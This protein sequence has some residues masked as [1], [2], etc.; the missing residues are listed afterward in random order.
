MCRPSLSQL[1]DSSMIYP[2]YVRGP[3][4]LLGGLNLKNGS[5]LS[6][7]DCVAFFYKTLFIS[8]TF[9]WF[10]IHLW[11]KIDVPCSNSTLKCVSGFSLDERTST[12]NS[13][14]SHKICIRTLRIVS[15]T[16][17]VFLI[18]SCEYVHPTPTYNK[19][20]V[21]S[22]HYKLPPPQSCDTYMISLHLT[23]HCPLS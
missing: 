1:I 4:S 10:S 11:H 21:L 18:W 6:M 14:R 5:I 17:H 20:I 23:K 19:M 22:N 7:I 2:W 13:L 8:I 15:S 3:P 12:S 16:M 9:L